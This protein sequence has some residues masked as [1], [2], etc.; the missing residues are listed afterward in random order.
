MNKEIEL[1]DIALDDWVSRGLPRSWQPYARLI[2]I[3]R[4]IGIWLALLPTLV[5][6]ILSRQ[7]IPHF[8]DVLLFTGGAIMMRGA[9]CTV[10]DIC[11]RKYDALVRRTRNRPLAS[12]LLTLK[13]AV[14]ALLVQLLLAAFLVAWLN[15]STVFL[16][17]VCV[18]LTLLYPLFKRFTHWP[19]L[20]LGAAFN[21]G[22]LMACTQ[23]TGAVRPGAF[24]LWLGS[25]F[26]QLGYDTIY[27]YCDREDDVRIGLRS[28]AT[29][30]GSN[31][32]AWI[33]GFYVLTVICWATAGW[34]QQVAASYFIMLLPIS[35]MFIFQVNKFDTERP[36]YCIPLFK[37]NAFV[38]MLLLI[39]ASA[40][41]I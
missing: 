21:W 5:S 27:A 17:M 14:I 23:T 32:R 35:L 40:A 34:L 30:L 20:F 19:Q 9:G 12:G 36:D 22:V 31:G 13:E 18:P 15:L 11:D 3:D 25:I 39:G 41:F 33:T 2:R 1:G 10:N 6:L 37:S 29:Y 24:I 26:W 38:G 7:G 4:P 8:S 16:A 28:T